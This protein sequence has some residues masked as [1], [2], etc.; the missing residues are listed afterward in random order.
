MEL[1]Y[2]SINNLL[3]KTFSI[4]FLDYFCPQIFRCNITPNETPDT[5]PLLS[6]NLNLQL[7]TVF[8]V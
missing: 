1:R 3:N 7:C 2:T 8:H 6:V 4:T 5:R